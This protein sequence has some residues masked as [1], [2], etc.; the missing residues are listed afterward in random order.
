MC[1]QPQYCRICLRV[2]GFMPLQGVTKLLLTKIPL[3]REVILMSFDCP[4][5]NYSNSEI[6]PGGPIQ[7]QGVKYVLNLSQKEASGA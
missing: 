2:H 6:Q 7:D 3:F 5:C 1:I 4:H